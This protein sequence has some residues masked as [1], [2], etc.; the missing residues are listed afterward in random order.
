[1]GKFHQMFHHVSLGLKC[2]QAANTLGYSPEHQ[3][4]MI[5]S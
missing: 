4:G 3:S 2:L 1:M 5:E